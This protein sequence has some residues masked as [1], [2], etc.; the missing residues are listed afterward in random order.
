M[1]I[2][3]TVMSAFCA[4]T[5]VLN[6]G[7]K[8]EI[9]EA[10]A[11][12]IPP[13]SVAGSTVTFRSN[14]EGFR[15]APVE[16]ADATP[17]ALPGRLAWDEDRTVRIYTPFS[18]RVVRIL[19]RT[20]DAVK[21]GEPLA[22]LA[23]AD[24]GQAQ[25][26][27]GKAAADRTLARQSVQR[28]EDLSR[29][30]VVAQKDLEQAR[31]DS[32]RADVEYERTQTRLHQVD[33][34]TG[35]T[36]VLKTPI[37]GTI[38][39]RA[40]NPGQELRSDQ[41]GPPIFLISDPQKLWVW[42]DAPESEISRLPQAAS[43]TSFAL[44][45]AAYPN[46][47]FT[48]HVVQSAEFID[49]TSRT[50]KLRGVV[51]NADRRLKAEMYV[52]VSLAARTDAPSPAMQRVPTTAVFLDGGHRYAFVKNGARQFTRVEVQVLREQVDRLIVAGIPASAQVVTD[53]SLYLQQFLENA[54]PLPRV[55]GAT[56]V[57]R[58]LTAAASRS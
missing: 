18:G 2:R 35:R 33:A 56:T 49:P 39:D 26:E 58:S 12:T 11:A 40:V 34:G 13:V 19:V 38:V 4:A 20:G 27:A 5:V 37:A 31:A 51:D 32:R 30:G 52:S 50:F 47:K 24:F 21:A 43:E 9:A 22:E 36:F 55:D 57:D 25:A 16:L 41:A 6:A 46:D 53:G 54:M 28:A 48:G 3:Q 1:N 17:L 23:S 29:A 14:P 7:C 45:T 10:E 15:T 8:Q 42:L 44:S